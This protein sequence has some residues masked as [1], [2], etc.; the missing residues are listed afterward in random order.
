ME[1]RPH[2]HGEIRL[3]GHQPEKWGVVPAAES[4]EKYAAV[5]IE[6]GLG[7]EPGDRVVISI[8]VQLPEFG[9]IL[10]ETAY[11]AGADSVDVLWFDDRVKRARF[12][13]GS[14]T[15]ATTVSGESQFRMTA[16]EAGASFLRVHAEDPAA[17]AGVDM[18]RVQEHQRVNGKYVKPHLEAM[19]ALVIPW[20][21]IGAPL[22]AWNRSV[23]PD[24][25]QAE[26]EEM[27]W[28]AIFR[29]CR[30]DQNDPVA[31][32]HDHLADL[33]ARAAHLT[34]RRFV[35]LRY[36]GPGTDLTLGMT[37]AVT[38]AG[39]A[40]ITPGGKRFAA[41]LP[42]EEVFTSPHR[43]KAEG[44]VASTKPLS[45]FG[46]LVEDFTLELS[47]GKV[48]SARAGKGQ[49][50][51][52]RILETDDGSVRFGEA[53]M[54]PQ[55]GAVAAEKLVWNNALFDENDACHIA[56]GQSYSSCYDG[57]S[58]MS[59]EQ[60]VEAGLNQSNVHVDFVVG[61]PGLSVY[62]VHDDGSEEPIIAGGEWGFS[63]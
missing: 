32:W 31:V 4:L 13:H 16:F 46:D 14:E 25:D 40:S 20:C 9:A 3:A 57:A 15:A 19:G 28:S 56:L 53:A 2:T 42:T 26:A 23:F 51:L 8:P 60:R 45:Y 61:S 54:V 52:D 12:A 21:V 11:D 44:S 62:G 27:M 30:V 10:V 22:P 5:A 47:E 59:V 6:V 39:G 29:A 49:E 1:N 17:F 38:W 18:N 63:V 48:V 58:G 34:E 41:N 36:E 50:V 43:M 35:A 24:E 7:V 37:N 55:S 33:N